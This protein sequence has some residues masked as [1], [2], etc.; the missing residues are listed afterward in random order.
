MSRRVR[1]AWLATVAAAVAAGLAEWWSGVGCGGGG[2]STEGCDPPC[3]VTETCV[4]G[5]CEPNDAGEVFD[6]PPDEVPDEVEDEAADEAAGEEASEAETADEGRADVDAAGFNI[7]AACSGDGDCVGLGTMTCLT[8]IVL[9]FGTYD[10]PG[11][12]CS[13]SCDAADPGSCGPGSWCISLLAWVQCL[14]ACTPGTP[15][16]CREAENYTCFDPLSMP[17]LGLP[18]AFCIPQFY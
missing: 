6:A 12:Y 2:S 11:G 8:T 5:V 1:S 16:E 13:S 9:P 14:Q 15:G 17:Y 10:V 3:A 4:D 18:G 7:G